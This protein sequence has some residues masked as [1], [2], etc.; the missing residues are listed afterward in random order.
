MDVE[1]KYDD[2]YEKINKVFDIEKYVTKELNSR[3]KGEI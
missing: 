3:G 1:E 2:D